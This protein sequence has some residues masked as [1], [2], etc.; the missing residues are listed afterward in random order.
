MPLYAELWEILSAKGYFKSKNR[1]SGKG[2]LISMEIWWELKNFE[3][4]Y[5]ISSDG[6]VKNI[7]TDQ[8]LRHSPDGNGYPKIC[9][10]KNDVRIYRNVHRLVAETFIPNPDNLPI[11]NH[12]D[13][14]IKNFSLKN[15]EWTTRGR[16]AGYR[17]TR[18][19]FGAHREGKSKKWRAEIRFE[20]RRIKLGLFI[21]RDLALQAYREK[22]FELYGS[23]PW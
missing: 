10:F 15:L 18:P 7:K 4:I 20:K 5:E 3:G 19:I 14:N 23:N 1:V 12:L 17:V 21:S 13:S 2:A 16:N 9:L 8:I 11:V 22:Y 6:S